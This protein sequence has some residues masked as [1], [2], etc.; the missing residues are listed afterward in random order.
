M[1][2]K[3]TMSVD[4][5]K[6]LCNAE[7]EKEAVKEALLFL[8]QKVSPTNWVDRIPEFIKEEDGMFTFYV[9]VSAIQS[10]YGKFDFENRRKGIILSAFLE[11]AAA[12]ES[13]HETSTEEK[14]AKADE[15]E[16]EEELEEELEELEE[17]SE[18]D[19]S[20]DER[21]EADRLSDIVS[22][23]LVLRDG[24]KRAVSMEKA[25]KFCGDAITALE[26]LDWR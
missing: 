12:W 22:I 20:E 7:K 19:K 23:V 24:T 9:N 13:E 18:E 25:R 14:E 4:N 8:F 2:A 21:K 10:G 1:Y 6:R 3:I 26:A 16:S 15:K 11:A 5:M 17:E